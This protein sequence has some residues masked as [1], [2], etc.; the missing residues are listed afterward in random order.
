MI[1]LAD[2]DAVAWSR[3]LAEL[4]EAVA[5]QMGIEEPW[6]VGLAGA[7]S[8]VGTLT[9]PR[10]VLAK[11]KAGSHLNTEERHAYNRVAEVGYH[12]LKDIP[13]LDGVAEMV[14]YS[15]KDFNGG[16]YPADGRSGD[17]NPLGA[18]ILRVCLDFMSTRAWVRDPAQRVC[19]M[20]YCQL[21]IYD[22]AVATALKRI[23]QDGFFAGAGEPAGPVSRAI[24]IQDLVEGQVLDGS[25]ETGEGRL[26]LRQGTVLG[27]GHLERL[28]KFER[29]GAI[30]GPVQVRCGP[31]K[32][33]TP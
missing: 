31:C 10:P 29:I 18:R 15:Q 16:G 21:S 11:V 25:I 12:L 22:P 14:H 27:P 20:L 8:R 17:E 1:S 28:L 7:L 19:D 9:I 26:L 5:V 32:E 30:R 33:S 4:A 23:I 13:R 6:M 3:S 24:R 2:P